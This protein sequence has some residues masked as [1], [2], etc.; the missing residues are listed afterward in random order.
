MIRRRREKRGL[1]ELKKMSTIEAQEEVRTS[2]RFA[3]ARTRSPTSVGG[4][5]MEPRGSEF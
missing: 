4:T 1:I 3:E 5:H 2:A